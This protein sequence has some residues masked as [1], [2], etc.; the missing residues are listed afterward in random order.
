MNLREFIMPQGRIF[1]R[2]H[3]LLNRHA[4][5]KNS[6]FIV[7]M[8]SLK[9]VPLRD[10]KSQ[11]NIQANDADTRKGQWLTEAGLRVD[12]GGLTCGYHGN[13]VSVA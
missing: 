5:Y 9:W 7:D 6:A 10:T 2:T 13:F 12:R 11:E 3:P 1:L 8:S 4:Q